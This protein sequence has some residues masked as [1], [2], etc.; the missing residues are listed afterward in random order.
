MY[1]AEHLAFNKAI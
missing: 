1:D